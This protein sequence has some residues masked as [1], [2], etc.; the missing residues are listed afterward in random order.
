MISGRKRYP[1]C[2]SASVHNW[3]TKPQVAN[4]QLISGLDFGQ[5]EVPVHLHLV[6]FHSDSRI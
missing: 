4:G 6:A 1:R 3:P 5:R 2:R